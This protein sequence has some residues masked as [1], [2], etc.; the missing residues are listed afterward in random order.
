MLFEIE[1]WVDLVVT[2]LLCVQA[3]KQHT[4]AHTVWLLPSACS[5]SNSKYH[6]LFTFFCT[7]LRAV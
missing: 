2:S 7:G 3:S 5:S 1:I 4:T 6:N